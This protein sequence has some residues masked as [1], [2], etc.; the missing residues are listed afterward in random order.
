MNKQQ[1]DK[2]APDVLADTGRALF[3]GPDW[4]ARLARA[5]GVRKD[6]IQHWRS[7]KMSL[8]PGHPALARLLALT[9]RRADEVCR[10][11]DDLREWLRRNR[12]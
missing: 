6:T 12:G 5:L 11:R 2:T 3:D 7:G 9:D 1:P 4:Q 10:A 8:D